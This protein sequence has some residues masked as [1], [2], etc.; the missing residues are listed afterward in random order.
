MELKTLERISSLLYV[1]ASV[2]LLFSLFKKGG[3]TTNSLIIGAGWISIFIA[4]VFGLYVHKK[5]KEL[6]S[7]K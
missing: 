1:I 2:L 4:A 7:V 3:N 6:E 5:K